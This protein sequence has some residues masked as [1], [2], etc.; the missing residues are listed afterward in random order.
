MSAAVLPRS[1][2]M[3]FLRALPVTTRPTQL[4]HLAVS[5]A[6]P[7]TLANAFRFA[8]RIQSTL[9]SHMLAA[10]FPT[11]QKGD[12]APCIPEVATAMMLIAT[13]A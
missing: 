4:T 13:R 5:A 6:A 9:A 12:D 3:H 2:A 10:G 7:D 1:N 8:R 11:E